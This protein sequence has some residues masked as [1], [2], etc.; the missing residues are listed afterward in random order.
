[1][2]EITTQIVRSDD[3]L[4]LARQPKPPTMMLTVSTP[5]AGA[6][7]VVA[8]SIPSPRRTSRRTPPTIDQSPRPAR[9]HLALE[10]AL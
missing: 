5:P 6:A 2:T 9:S 7:A 8:A 1:M 3:P 10:G 4:T